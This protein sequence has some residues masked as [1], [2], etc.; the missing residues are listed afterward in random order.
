MITNNLCFK[1]K[2]RKN[3]CQTAFGSGDLKIHCH[4]VNVSV[5]MKFSLKTSVIIINS[6]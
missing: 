5:L 2:M 1:A 3:E 4:N 6:P